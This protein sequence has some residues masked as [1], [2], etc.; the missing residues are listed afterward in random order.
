MTANKVVYEV[1]V[2]GAE[3]ATATVAKFES[4]LAQKGTAAA[5]QLGD[6]FKGLSRD[7]D[8]IGGQMTAGAAK[9]ISDVI[10]IAQSIGS[11]G[12]LGPVALLTT[13]VGI[14]VSLVA[15]WDEE[16]KELAKTRKK[17]AEDAAVDMKDQEQRL[18][19]LMDA[20]RNARREVSAGDLAAT[21]VEITERRKILEALERDTERQKDAARRFAK[22][23]ASGQA[24]AARI[25]NEAVTALFSARTALRAAEERKQ[26]EEAQFNAQ[27]RVTI[28][29]L[30][31]EAKADQARRASARAQA[32]LREEQSIEAALASSRA[33]SEKSSA[34][35]AKLVADDQREAAE[36]RAR[37]NKSIADLEA[38]QAEDEAAGSRNAEAAEQKAAEQLA[39]RT[40]KEEDLRRALQERE[41][42]QVQATKASLMDV[43]ANQ[44]HAASMMVITAAMGP[45]TQQLQQFG[46]IN[47]ENYRDMLTITENTVAAWAAIAQA[48]AWSLALQAGAK[49]I[50]ETAEA[51]KETALAF[52]S[53]AMYDSV[54]ASNHFISA[55]IHSTSAAAYAAIGGGAAGVS[56]GIGAMRGEGGL[57]G[58][59]KEE[60]E[61]QERER[62]G[63]G[64]RDTGP[65]L[66]GPSV[67][68]STGGNA[69]PVVV[70]F[71]YEAGAINAQDR[72]AAA[73][74]VARASSTVRRDGFMR[75]RAN[76]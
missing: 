36:E 17:A 68:G 62:N 47:R 9:G 4:T 54:G 63:P 57:V 56:L 72:D 31:D 29:K 26:T 18:R 28:A 19:G 61:K 3:A 59:T 53:I 35:H 7:I 45:V 55:G 52:G 37:W 65:A 64:G 71:V 39:R 38:L 48:A 69:G 2:T 12:M 33:A 60:R 50:Y 21:D 46:Q 44:T 22:D 43:A 27:E 5:S 6:V 24:E 11:A 8:V 73:A 15:A 41:A 32:R 49:S 74:T 58:L 13:G 40:E 66:G 16:E 10:S 1:E 30:E 34:D 51:Y 25:E 20:A 14:L 76:G 70:N 75:R 42:A 23:F 67:R